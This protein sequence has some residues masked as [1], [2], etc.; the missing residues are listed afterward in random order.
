MV[1]MSWHILLRQELQLKRERLQCLSQ[2]D[3]SCMS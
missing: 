1:L 3:E 2:Q